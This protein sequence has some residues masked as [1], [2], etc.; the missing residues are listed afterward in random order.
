MPGE[1][2]QTVRKWQEPVGI[3]KF[4]TNH[5]LH[6][7]MERT[8]NDSRPKALATLKLHLAK[9]TEVELAPEFQAVALLNHDLKPARYLR[10]DTWVF[11]VS[12]DGGLITIHTGAAKR[13][14]PLGTKP[15]KK[16]RKRRR[17]R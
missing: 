1:E 11:V 5:A 16:R 4:V 7:W 12:E 17:P 2:R 3:V 15:L 8:R 9:A 14:V 10:F 6:R 13:W